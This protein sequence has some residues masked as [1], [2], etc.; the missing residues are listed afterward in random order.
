[1]AGRQT[2]LYSK[3]VTKNWNSLTRYMIRA[4]LDCFDL[5]FVHTGAGS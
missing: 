3:G 1:M 4:D 2:H 5:S